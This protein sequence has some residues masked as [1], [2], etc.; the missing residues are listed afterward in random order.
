[1]KPIRN[2]S[3]S[4]ACHQAAAGPT[5][6][7]WLQLPWSYSMPLIILAGVLHWLVGRSLFLVRI[8]VYGWN[9]A[10]ESWRDISAC[11]YSPLAILLVMLLLDLTVLFY[12]YLAAGNWKMGCRSRV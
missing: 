9:S 8:A 3:E 1:M 12:S 5:R 2:T 7:Y 11:G 10:R 4:V 6:T